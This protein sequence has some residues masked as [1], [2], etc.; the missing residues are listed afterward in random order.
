MSKTALLL[1]VL[2]TLFS[3][4]NQ[5]RSGIFTSLQP[6]ETGIDFVNTVN[7][8]Q[9]TK[10]SMN[11]FGY[12]GGGVGIGDF[13]RDGLKDI[14]F[15]A[16]QQSS[17]LYLNK[18]NNKFEDITKT[19][20]LETRDWCT[21]V[22]IVDINADGFDDIFV[23][24]YGHSLDDPIPNKLFIN[25]KN[26]TFKEEAAAYGLTDAAYTTQVLFFDYDGDG[27]L[28]VFMLNY[29]LNASYSA[30]NIY[31]KDLSGKS[32]AADKLYRNDGDSLHTGHPHFTD[33]TVEAG[34]ID[35]G[36]GLGVSVSDLNHDGWPDIYVSNDFL[37]NDELWLNNRN[38]TFTDVLARATRHQSYNSMGCDAADINNDGLIDFA[39]LDMMPETNER[40]KLTDIMTGYDRYEA[41]RQLGY[42]PEFTRNMLQLNNG[43]YSSKDTTIPFFSEIGQYA[44]LSETDWSWS[45]LFADFTNDGLKDAHITNG[46]GRD[47]MSADFLQFSK[48][49]NAQ[50]N[51]PATARTIMN[52]KLAGQ[53]PLALPDYFFINTGNGSFKDISDSAGINK[54][55]MSN[56]AAYVDLDNDGDLDIVVNNINISPYIF[57]N[58]T[59]NKNKPVVNHSISFELKGDGMNTKAF[60]ARVMMYVDGRIQVQEVAP[61]RGF[62]SSVDSRLLFGT[63][64]NKVIDSVIIAWPGSKKTILTNLQSDSCYTILVKDAA[65]YVTEQPAL[66][67]TIF[68]DV[69][70]NYEISYTHTDAPWFDYGNQRMLPQKYSQLGPYIST[71]DINGDGLLDFFVGGGF[72]SPGKIFT[73]LSNG[74]FSS[75]SLYDGAKF[76][77]DED[78]AFFDADGDADPDLLISYGDVRFDDTSVNYQPQLFLNDGKGNFNLSETAIPAS[79]K[80]I[81]GCVAVGDF[82]ADGQPDIFIGGRVSKTY[83]AIPRSFLLKNNHGIF[84]DVTEQVCPALKSAGMITAATWADL[85]GD[86]KLDLA[87]T[88]EYMPVKLFRNDS[89]HFT[90][91][92]NEMQLVDMHGMWRSLIA[93]DVDNDGDED[94]IAGN[95]G[96]NNRYHVT[97]QQPM[98][99]FAKDID[100]NGSVDPFLFYYIKTSAGTKKLYPAS[101]RDIMAE[102]VPGL[103][104]KFLKHKDFEGAGVT[105]IFGDTT[106]ILSFKCDEM[107][108]CWL[109]NTGAGKFVKHYLPA[110]AQFA[111]VNALLCGDFNQDGSKDI[112]F[113]GNEYQAEVNTGRYDAS[114]GGLLTGDKQKMFTWLP[115]SRSGIKMEGD[116]KSMKQIMIKN[117]SFILAAANAGRLQLY[118]LN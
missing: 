88:G 83:P 30:N 107:A 110:E 47:F 74:I 95:M 46:I 3:C 76:R 105:D 31:P 50:T 1:W 84:T 69:T 111:P 68:K 5:K 24:T 18:G 115:Y 27:D 116:I 70:G 52:E 19:A 45:I 17:K 106:N 81:A 22:S 54:P 28:D 56:G 77:E 109:E 72:N 71:G 26:N 12:M 13:N 85:N 78:C 63:G 99:L 67:P 15:C 37:S 79:V 43:N 32:K 7:E 118:K 100:G 2:C 97:A 94:L 4:Q 113:A 10:Q 59:N 34:I 93:A 92:T 21:G 108:S 20:G 90:D 38:G 9:F 8:Q 41:E 89:G 104:K 16:N 40:K 35:D 44:G 101:G 14:F 51:D 102:Q 103:K 49:V 64:Q 42:T 73:Q 65:L 66:K 87:L 29:L 117:E 33:V 53:P 98:T 62:L 36:Y 25:Q 114:Y 57:I 60:G 82:D 86:K 91:V 80:T 48:D 23:C 39:T 58:Q 6:A 75:K 55:A 112:I 96:L 61:V 11:E